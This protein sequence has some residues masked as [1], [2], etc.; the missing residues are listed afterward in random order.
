MGSQGGDVEEGAVEG[1]KGEIELAE[2]R[3]TFL[4]WEVKRDRKG[5]TS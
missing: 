1:K 3:E 2:E 4:F 5:L